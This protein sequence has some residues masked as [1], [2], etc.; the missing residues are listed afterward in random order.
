MTEKGYKGG[1][2]SRVKN[3]YSGKRYIIS[4]AQEIGK[5][6]WT[7]VILVAGFFGLFPKSFRPLLTWVR[8]TKEEAHKVHW[9]I[10]KIVTEEPEEE[11]IKLAPS[12]TPPNGYSEDA[13]RTFKKKLGFIPDEEDI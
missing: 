13:K 3:K 4:T 6:Y 8:N 12:P 5:D 11:W 9:E 1:L 2:V 10:K 7:T